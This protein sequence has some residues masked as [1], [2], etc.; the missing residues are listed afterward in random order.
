MASKS[1]YVYLYNGLRLDGDVKQCVNDLIKTFSCRMFQ[2]KQGQLYLLYEHHR[3]IE[4]WKAKRVRVGSTKMSD[5]TYY[6]TA[7]I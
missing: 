1:D 7:T 5:G 6:Q 4:W 3:Y 2:V